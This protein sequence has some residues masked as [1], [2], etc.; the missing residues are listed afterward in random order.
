MTQERIEKIA[1]VLNEN[2]SRAKKLIEMDPV[3]AAEQLKA[4]GYDFT[5]DELIEFGEFIAKV[6]EETGELDVE[7]LENVAGGVVVAGAVVAAGVK[8]FLAGAAGGWII[9]KKW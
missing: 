2:E 1:E 7:N 5:S 6:K 9:S 3:A 4:E 8:I